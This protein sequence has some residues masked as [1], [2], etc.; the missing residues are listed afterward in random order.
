MTIFQNKQKII[1]RL[2]PI[3][4]IIIDSVPS[5]SIFSLFNSFIIFLFQKLSFIIPQHVSSF[6]CCSHLCFYHYVMKLDIWKRFI[7]D[8]CFSIKI[9]DKTELGFKKL[10]E[11][12]EWKK[13]R[14]ALFIMS[15]SL[16]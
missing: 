11:I 13:K 12:K 4:I 15:S 16:Q 5:I 14:K 10:Y 3:L 2:D 1:I 9:P 6:F 8:N 7:S